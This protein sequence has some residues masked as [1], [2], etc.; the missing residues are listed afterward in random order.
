MSER[1]NQVSAIDQA[2]ETSISRRGL[3]KRAAVVG[4]GSS[5]LVSLLAACDTDEEEDDVALVDES[6]DDVDGLDDEDDEDVEPVDAP[7]D[8][9]EV[10]ADEN[11]VDDP[12]DDPDREDARYGG[13]LTVAIP[14]DPGTVEVMRDTTYIGFM[15]FHT[16]ELLFTWNEDM[17]VQPELADTREV[18]DDGLTNTVTLREGVLFHDGHEMTA[19]DV[20]ASLGRWF[21]V[22]PR[23]EGL[24]SRVDE[25]EQIDDLTVVFHMNEP[26]GAFA[27]VLAR[28]AAGCVIY[29]ESVLGDADANEAAPDPIG[30]GPYEFVEYVSDQHIRM[31]RFDDFVGRDEEP[32]GY[33]G[34]KSA[35]IDEL[36]FVPAPDEAAQVAGLQAGDFQYLQRVNPDQYE[37]LER[38]DDVV[39][40]L[41]PSV[42]G[43]L[44][45][46]NTQEGPLSDVT[47]RQAV[48]ACLDLEEM[49]VAGVGQGHFELDHGVQ[50]EG[51]AWH[52]P[53]GEELHNQADPERAQELLEEA[54]YN[55]ETV[56]LIARNDQNDLYNMALVVQQQ[57]EDIGM[58]IELE[59]FD[60]ATF[61]EVREDPNAWNIFP[62]NQGI[63]TDPLL[64][65]YI[66]ATTWPGWWD[67][68]RKVE[69]V[70]Q[71]GSETDFDAR[72]EIWEELHRVFYEEDVP[73]VKI[74]NVLNAVARSPRLQGFEPLVEIAGGVPFWN[75]WLED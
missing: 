46:F 60:Q 12:D 34:R 64:I 20:I 35:Y 9:D 52:T 13:T 14:S 56:T 16:L 69:L 57:L 25:L 5:V 42:E 17:E 10:D 30:T 1:P 54:G 67:S 36:M 32:S 39:A 18:S 3:M 66:T 47:M 73:M 45:V 71:L 49:L 27:E 8:H 61:F 7:D 74:G 31:A 38:D 58:N 22:S 24:S 41:L 6:D 29:P 19:T 26:Y 37:I 43:R 53:V 63:T 51:T 70:R 75:M 65:S 44:I 72:Y 15:L 48:Q 68:D 2:F 55:G 28:M 33:S 4:I 21:E 11:S 62:T 59:V 40:E 23:P 50:F